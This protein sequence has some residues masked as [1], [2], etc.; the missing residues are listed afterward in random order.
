MSVM[1]AVGGAA[2]GALATY[3]K[4]GGRILPASSNPDVE[5]MKQRIRDLEIALFGGSSASP[6]PVVPSPVMPPVQP[7]IDWNSLLHKL[8]DKV[9]V[10]A[11]PAPPDKPA[12]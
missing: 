6:A 5:A 10:P 3:W 4:G 1:M 12:A 9:T 7:N 11:L 2:A 8:I